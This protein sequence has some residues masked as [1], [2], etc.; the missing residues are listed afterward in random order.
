MESVSNAEITLYLSAKICYYNKTN[1]QKGPKIMPYKMLIAEDE[2][3][4]YEL[5]LFLLHKLELD[6]HLQIYHAENGRQALKILEENSIELLLTDIEMPF[7]NGLEIAA[8]ARAKNPQLPIVFFSCYDNFSYI[9]TALTVQANNYLLKPLDPVE[10]EK[11]MLH[12][13]DLLQQSRLQK[14]HQN[15]RIQALRNHYL[16]LKLNR[17][18][19]EDY[20]A[21]EGGTAF[22]DGYTQLLL[23][24]FEESFFDCEP[25]ISE[26]FVDFLQN[27]FQRS[28]DFV[29]LNPSQSVLLFKEEPANAIAQDQLAALC[30]HI[31]LQIYEDYQIHCYFALSSPLSERT[32]LPDAYEDA[33]GLLETRFFC[34]DRYVF[35]KQSVPTPLPENYDLCSEILSSIKANVDAGNTEELTADILRLNQI[36]EQNRNYSHIYVRYIYSSLIQILYCNPDSPDMPGDIERI[37]SC[38]FI[39]EIEQIVFTVLSRLQTK[40]PG[41]SSSRSHVIQLARQYI[42]KHY[43]EQLCLHDIASA[44]YLNPSYLSTIFKLETGSSVNKYMKSVRMEKAKQILTQTNKKVSDVGA[45]V[46]YTNPSYF[47]KSF[48]EYFGETP[49]K[50]RQK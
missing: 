21:I 15:S 6:T 16:Y 46:G 43:H 1:R 30:R 26:A 4:E 35:Y 20:P 10:F 29:N 9:K 28:F 33:C 12:V 40:Q 50:M 24:H 45:A 8:K 18:P 3:E 27:Q 11:T 41:A 38:S 5:V 31:H 39:H 44:V 7:A 25:K 36:F 42:H 34:Q 2:L 49:D 32:E 47:I 48:H 14:K 13:F 17:M 37:F 22:A 19:C 23:L